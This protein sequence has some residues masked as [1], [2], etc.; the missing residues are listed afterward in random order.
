MSAFPV[1]N[2]LDPKSLCNTCN[3]TWRLTHLEWV[4]I[5]NRTKLVLGAVILSHSVIGCSSNAK[6][7]NIFD[8]QTSER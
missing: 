1:K 2:I 4:L 3:A 5:M 7:I 6:S 8:V